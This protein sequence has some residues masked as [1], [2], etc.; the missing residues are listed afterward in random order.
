MFKRIYTKVKNNFKEYFDAR[1]TVLLI[2]F[3]I[4]IFISIIVTLYLKYNYVK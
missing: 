1:N 3:L 2:V 4:I